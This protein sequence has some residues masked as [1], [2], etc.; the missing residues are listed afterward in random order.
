MTIS[1]KFPSKGPDENQAG[2]VRHW[3]GPDFWR[4]LRE[5]CRLK[6][7]LTL[8]FRIKQ[9]IKIYSVYYYVDWEVFTG[10]IIKLKWPEKK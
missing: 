5:I 6:A 1:D 9:G 2:T 7:T 10:P 4:L 8:Y 3:A